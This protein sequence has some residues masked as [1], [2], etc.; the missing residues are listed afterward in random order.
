MVVVVPGVLTIGFVSVVSVVEFVIIEICSV[1]FGSG[2]FIL[3]GG[4]ALRP[5]RVFGFRKN[6]K[7]NLIMSFLNTF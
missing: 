5:G 3:G 7:L 6:L 4:I 1:G 2:D